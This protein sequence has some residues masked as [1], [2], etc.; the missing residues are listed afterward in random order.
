MLRQARFALARNGRRRADEGREAEESPTNLRE[1]K[2]VHVEIG[3]WECLGERRT[4]G[5][6]NGEEALPP[7]IGSAPK[8]KGEPL[9]AHL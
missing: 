2:F 8:E 3:R 6:E 7:S 1:R 4:G 9:P 5:I